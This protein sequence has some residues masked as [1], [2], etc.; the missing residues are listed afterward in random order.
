[1][2][3]SD[4]FVLT[5]GEEYLITYH[6]CFNN[7]HMLLGIYFVYFVI[8]VSR[9]HGH[10]YMTDSKMY[11][12]DGRCNMRHS[13]THAMTKNNMHLSTYLHEMSATEST[14]LQQHNR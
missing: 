12:T 8:S 6:S 11:G 7:V 13:P 5:H 3:L 9:G 4:L 2:T 10:Y 14:S 1:M